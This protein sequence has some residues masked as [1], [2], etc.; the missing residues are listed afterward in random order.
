MYDPGGLVTK[1]IDGGNHTAQIFY[2]AVGHKTKSL[3]SNGRDH[4]LRL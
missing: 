2:D 3:D 4:S 1:S